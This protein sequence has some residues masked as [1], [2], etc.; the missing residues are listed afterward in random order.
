MRVTCVGLYPPARW[1]NVFHLDLTVSGTPTDS[2]LEAVL[3]G[4]NTAYVTNLLTPLNTNVEYLGCEGVYYS[5]GD[6]RRFIS[7]STGVGA[8]DDGVALPANVACAISWRISASY[9]GG[10]PRTYLCGLNTEQVSDTARFTPAAQAAIQAAASAFRGDMNAITGGTS[11]TDT[12]LGTVSYVLD[13]DWRAT[14]LFRPFTGEGVDARIDS[15][16]RRLGRDI[17]V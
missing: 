8:N 13:G 6:P 1:A 17:A 16:R 15:Q 3:D 12:R 4:V 10:H 7:D 9:R 14:P 11:V 5:A 2:D